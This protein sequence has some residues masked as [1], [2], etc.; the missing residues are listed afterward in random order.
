MFFVGHGTLMFL[1]ND[2]V[3]HIDP[4]SREAD[5]GNMPDAVLILYPCQYGHTDTSE[6]VSLLENEQ[7]IEVRVR[8]LQ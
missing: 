4:T 5:Y 7:E 1:Y 2:L 3:I 6:L 8:Q